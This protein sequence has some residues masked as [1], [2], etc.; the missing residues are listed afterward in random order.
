M[1]FILILLLIFHLLFCMMVGVYGKDKTG[2]FWPYFWISFF[3]T[4]VFGF[5]AVIMDA[6]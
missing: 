1:E 4:P 5:G 6:P 3:M 2:K